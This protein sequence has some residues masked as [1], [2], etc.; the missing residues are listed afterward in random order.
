[1][2]EPL[3][4]QVVGRTETASSTGRAASTRRSARTRRCSPTWCGACWRTAPTRRSSTASPIQ[5]MSHR[6]AGRRSGRSVERMRDAEGALGLPHPT[7]PAAARRCTAPSARNS[8][9][10]RPRRTRQRLRALAGACSRRAHDAWTRRAA[11]SARG[12]PRGDGAPVRNPGRPARRRRPGRRGRRATTSRPR[13]QR[14]RRRAPTLGGDAAGRARARCLERAADLLEA[15]DAARCSACSCARPA[16]PSP[17]RSPKCARRSTSCATTRRRRARDFDNDDASRRSARSSASA[18]GTSRW[19][20]SPARSRA[21]LAA[22]NPVL[23]KPAEQT[24]LIAAEA[25]RLLH[26]AGVPARRAAAAARAAA[27]PSARRWSPIAR[28]AGVMFTGSTE[29][30]RLLQRT[31]AGRLGADGRADPADRRDRRPERDDR[32][33]VGAGRAGRRRR[34]RLGVRQRRPALLGAARAVRAGRRRRPRARRCSRARCASCAS[35]TRAR[36]RPTSA[37]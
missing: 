4:E 14:A 2:G 3:Y 25:V 19:R 5:P 33:L 20:S 6:R 8:Q 1:M 27:R 31:L 35:A 10:P 32:R 28:V 11:C 26:E 23:A 36:S 24:P 12:E 9:R 17:T 16:R 30:A 15:R 29:V 34:R 22:G 13:S 18:R 7:H 37:R 21:A